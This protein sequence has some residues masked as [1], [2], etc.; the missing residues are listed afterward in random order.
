M[1]THTQLYS[2]PAPRH[3]LFT[4]TRG[5]VLTATIPRLT[6][7]HAIVQAQH[8]PYDLSR[9]YAEH[10]QRIFR[11]MTAA[12]VQPNSVHFGTLMDCQARSWPCSVHTVA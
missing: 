4:C 12:G 10:A 7:Q 6:Q 11:E 9:D 2:M 1:L 8:P 5:W 3:V